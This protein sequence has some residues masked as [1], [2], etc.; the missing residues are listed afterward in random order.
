MKGKSVPIP[1]RDNLRVGTL[2]RGQLEQTLRLLDGLVGRALGQGVGRQRGLVLWADALAGDAVEGGLEAV[3]D[4]RAGRSAQQALFGG[5]ARK[6]EGDGLAVAVAEFVAAAEDCGVYSVSLARAV[7]G[8]RD[9]RWRSMGLAAAR[10][11][12]ARVRS[13]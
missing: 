5:R 12:N 8:K 4:G 9:L 13:L 2:L 3:A 10:E 11:A 7:G 1:P 6:D